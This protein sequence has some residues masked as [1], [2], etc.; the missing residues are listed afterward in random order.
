MPKANG[1]DRRTDILHCIVYSQPCGDATAGTVDIEVYRFRRVL[2]FEEEELGNDGG[3]RAFIDFAIEGDDA[4]LQQAGEDV[5][6][7]VAACLCLLDER[8]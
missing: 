2:S 6:G 4:F 7:L 8:V 1:G 3:R 5:R